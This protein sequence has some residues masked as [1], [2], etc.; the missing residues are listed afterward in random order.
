MAAWRTIFDFGETYRLR[1]NTGIA[2]FGS[3]ALNLVDPRADFIAGGIVAGDI[4]ENLSDGSVGRVNTIDSPTTLT[5]IGLNFGRNNVFSDNDVYR[6]PRYNGRNNTR[7]GLLSVHE[8]G[9]TFPTGFTVEWR[10]PVVAGSVVTGLVHGTQSL[11][12]AAVLQAIQSSP[13]GDA[14]SVDIENG[15]CTWL[16]TQVAE[17]TGSGVPAPYLEGVATSGSGASVLVDATPGFHRGGR[18]NRVTSLMSRTPQS[19]P[20]SIQPRY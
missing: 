10:V 13:A 5:A 1:S 3:S 8:P 15:Q 16:N 11:Y 14:I 17:C 9:K 12:A 20:M 7:K 19:L 6:L 18:Q 4:V 2:A